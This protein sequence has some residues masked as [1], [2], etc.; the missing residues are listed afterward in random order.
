[1]FVV[2]LVSL[3]AFVFRYDVNEDISNFHSVI[4]EEIPE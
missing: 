4:I 2:M 3:Q 1:M